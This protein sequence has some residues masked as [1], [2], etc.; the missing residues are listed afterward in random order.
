MSNHAGAKSLTTVVRAPALLDESV[1]N[2]LSA[3]TDM[4]GYDR[5]KFIAQIGAMVNASTL[6]IFAVES[7]ES[8]LGNA[9]NITGAALVQ[10]ANT[11]N[12]SVQIID[13]HRPSKRYVG[14]Y[15]NAG[16]AN[17]TLLGILAERFRGSGV[18]PATQTAGHQYVA[19]AAN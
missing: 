16:T 5:V 6:D 8:N 11:A 1:A 15:S 9:T 14:V 3:V 10:V 18:M 4:V 19:V 2:A 7:N 13:I 17:V 12:N